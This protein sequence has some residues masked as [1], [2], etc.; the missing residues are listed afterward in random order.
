MGDEKVG[1]LLNERRVFKPPQKL[2][3]ESNVKKM[4]GCTRY[5]I[6]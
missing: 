5:K 6:V 2:V 3:D 4:D 1:V